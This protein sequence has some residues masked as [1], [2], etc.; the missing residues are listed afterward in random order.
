MARDHARILLTV[1]D[2]EDFTALT[3][4]Q[5]W[6][7]WALCISP[8]LSYCGI[9]PNLPKRL[10]QLASDQDPRKIAKAIEALHEHRFVIPDYDTDE[11]LIR[12]HIRHDGIIKRPNIIR[13][14]NKAFAK[15]HS[16]ILRDVITSEVAR[17]IDETYGI[18]GREA[19]A[20]R[21]HYFDAFAEGFAKE[22][23][24]G[25]AEPIR[26]PNEEGV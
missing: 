22:F 5:Q 7:Y 1:W 19:F 26:E 15:V 20:K 23:L 16:P 3:A 14:M 25:F 8:D 10:A 12:S 11:L 6:T 24:E 18:E 2:D 9:V 13:A 21:K 17:A 4:H